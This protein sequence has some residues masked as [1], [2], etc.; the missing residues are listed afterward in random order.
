MNPFEKTVSRLA[1]T[2]VLLD[3]VDSTNE[4]CKSDEIKGDV[5]VKA[6]RQL[7]G[8]GRMGRRFYSDEGGFYISYCF[9]PRDKIPAER[10]LPITGMCASVV[11]DAVKNTCGISPKIK[12][13]NDI[14]LDERK[15]CGIL[16]ESVISGGGDMEK[17]I[18]GIGINTNQG[19]EAFSELCNIASSIYVLSG[20]KVNEEELLL[21]LS[22]GIFRVYDALCTGDEELMRYHVE[23]YR[24]NCMT[25]GRE[26]SILSPHLCGGEDPRVVFEKD[27]RR[28]PT[29]RAVD[30]DEA[31][32]L[33]LQCPDGQKK[34][35][36]FGEVSVR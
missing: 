21:S 8:R 35:V 30:I 9:I 23:N 12:W 20:E 10:F 4:Y 3:E 13:T 34:T 18:I 22:Q 17:L 14:L 25:I 6:R 15:I 5:V 19:R 28:F 24:D 29:A 2:L 11:L 16:T 1:D 32:G 33:V 36:T 27:P 7:A 31:F 26:V